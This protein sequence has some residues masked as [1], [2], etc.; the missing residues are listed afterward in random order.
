[1][2]AQPNPDKDSERVREGGADVSSRVI[3]DQL[4]QQAT[5]I[6]D[7][8]SGTSGGYTTPDR[9]GNMDVAPTVDSSSPSRDGGSWDT[10]GA[11]D[12]GPLG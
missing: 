6:S 8:D 3:G 1:M 2:I 10:S 12:P 4:T 11:G 9:P 5:D 7:P